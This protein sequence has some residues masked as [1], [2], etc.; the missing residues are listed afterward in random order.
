MDNLVKF[1]NNISAELKKYKINAEFQIVKN[2]KY[3]YKTVFS[4]CIFRLNNPYKNDLIYTNGFLQLLNALPKFYE[5]CV[6]RLYFDNSLLGKD[7]LW[8]NFYNKLIKHKHLQLIKYNFNQLK[9]HPVFHDDLFGRG[10]S[11]Y[12]CRFSRN[13]PCPCPPRHVLGRRW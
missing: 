10:K 7:N 6:I 11:R 12:R 2:V 9:S 8:K 5:D 3:K 1:H 13:G 4:T